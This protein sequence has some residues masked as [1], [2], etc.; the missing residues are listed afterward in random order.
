MSTSAAAA[1]EEKEKEDDNRKERSLVLRLLL[2][3]TSRFEAFRVF[4]RPGNGRLVWN[5][6]VTIADTSGSGF[7]G[8]FSAEPAKTMIG[9]HAWLILLVKLIAASPVNWL[10][11][12]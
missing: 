11:S 9:L 5:S 2:I 7:F 4:H 8:E 10:I 12:Q 6:R 3:L 1:A